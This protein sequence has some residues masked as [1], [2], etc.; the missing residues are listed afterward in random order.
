MKIEKIKPR[1]LSKEQA[2]DFSDKEKSKVM[3]GCEFDPQDGLKVEK[4]AV[5]PQQKKENIVREKYDD[6]SILERTYEYDEI[7]REKWFRADG[8]IG[9]DTN[10]TVDKGVERF[11]QTSYRKDGTKYSESVNE[12]IAAFRQLSE[13]KFGR[14]GKDIVQKTYKNE[15]GEVL[16]ERYSDGILYVKEVAAKIDGKRK[17]VLKE[18]IVFNKDGSEYLH[19]TYGE[20]GEI[21]DYVKNQR[22]G[23]K[24]YDKFSEKKLD[25]KIDTS[26]KQGKAGTCY[27]ASTVQSFLLSDVGK[28]CINESLEYDEK[29][30]LSKV[31]LQGAKKEYT[32]TKDEIKKA[33]GRLGTGDPDFTA[34]IMGYEKYRTEELGKVVDGGLGDE[35]AKALTGKETESNLFFMPIPMDN[36]LLDKLQKKLE[37]KKTAVT[38]GTPPEDVDFEFSKKEEK[39]GFME[40]HSY[41]VK[42]I[43]D[44]N[45]TVINPNTQKEIKMTREKFLASFLTYASVDF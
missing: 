30:E 17:P 33:M 6:G 32:F 4:G 14:N 36:K 41:A 42:E 38:V 13:I 2:V 12:D 16:K 11:V 9:F 27:I 7:Q 21:L 26:F 10:R 35:V 39:A 24:N 31:K 5:E 28:E 43:T 20:K 8:T 40:S 34:L 18:R 29:T 25:G 45:V 22:I 19:T 15:N 37:T 3:F 44:K 23:K 1:N